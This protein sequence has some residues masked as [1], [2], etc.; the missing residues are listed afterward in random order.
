[1]QTIYLHLPRQRNTRA[2]DITPQP[3]WRRTVRTAL[4]LLTVMVMVPLLFLFGMVFSGVL[5][6]GTFGLL[7]WSAVARRVPTGRGVSSGR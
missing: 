6:A 4:A 2:I 3:W 5:L 7:T 1:M